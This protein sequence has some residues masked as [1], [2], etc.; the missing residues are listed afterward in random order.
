MKHLIT[1]GLIVG[2][3]AAS[4]AQATTIGP[5]TYTWTGTELSQTD[6][7]FRDGLA[8]TC[9][10]PKTYPGM[11]GTTTGQGYATFNFINPSASAACMVVTWFGDAEYGT[12]LSAYLYPYDPFNAAS[13][14]LGDAGMSTALTPISFSFMVPGNT[15]FSILANTVTGPTPAPGTSFTFTVDGEVAPWVVPEPSSLLLLGT[16]LVAL[17]ARKRR[18]R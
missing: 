2:V 8:S 9:A 3:L 7:L 10:S 16:G 1:I 5:V 4:T 12:F 18:M 11:V 14:Y 17:R 15:Q 13:N 6:R